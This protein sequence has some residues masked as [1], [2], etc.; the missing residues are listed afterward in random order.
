MVSTQTCQARHVGAV[1]SGRRHLTHVDGTELDIGAGDAHVIEPG[2][3]TWVT[4]EEP[5]VTHEFESAT[6]ETFPQ[7]AC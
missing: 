4:S 3:D 1:V 7:P 2:H 6:A 5:F